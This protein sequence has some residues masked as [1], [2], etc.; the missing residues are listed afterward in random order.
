[1]ANFEITDLLEAAPMPLIL[2]RDDERIEAANAAARDIFSLDM[3]GRHYVTMLRQPQVLGTIEAA[4]HHGT[5]GEVQVTL[6][7]I[8]GD[9]IWLMRTAPL[10]GGVLVSFEDRSSLEHASQMRRDFVANVSHE[11]RTPLTALVGFIQTLRGPA[12][13]DVAARD[14]FLAIME[15]EANRM[16][17]LVSDLLSLSRVEAQERMCPTTK[18]DLCAQMHAAIQSLGPAAKERDISV[19]TK[20]CDAPVIIAGDADQLLQVFS[21]LA[22]NAIKYGKKGGKVTITM[23]KLDHA[24]GLRKPAVRVDVRDQGDGIEAHHIQRLTERFYRVDDHRSREMGG[25]GLG[26]AIVKHIV[27]RHRGRLRI[28]SERGVGS[29]FS[30][31]LPLATSRTKTS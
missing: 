11:L 24:P 20:G 27:N 16:N 26:L 18:V 8:A 3:A 22:E 2:V 9:S 6:A 4:L 13:D 10:K 28:E 5:Y 17:R 31:T 25:T 19:E 1:M 12:R 29:T 15:R 21:N 30:V 7:S 14:R 23:T